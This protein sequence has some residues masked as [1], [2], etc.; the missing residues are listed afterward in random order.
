MVLAVDECLER[1]R[2]SVARKYPPD[3]RL[4]WAYDLGQ[5]DEIAVCM[6]FSD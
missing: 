3:F 6:A 4:P 5:R 2:K 1:S